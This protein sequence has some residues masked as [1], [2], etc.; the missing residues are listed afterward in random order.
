MS[1]GPDRQHSLNLML[2]ALKLP[3]FRDH[4]EELARRAEREGLSFSQFLHD[5]AEIE[6]DERRHRRIRRLQRASKLPADKTFANLETDRFTTS[7]QRQIPTLCE[8]H[9]VERA[10]NVLAFGLPGLP[11]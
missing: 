2:R 4:H 3:G 5:L 9:F 7:I 11:T 6:L 8:G 1:S 10:E